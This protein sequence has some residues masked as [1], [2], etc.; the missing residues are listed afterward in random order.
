[1]VRS[2]GVAAGVTRTVTQ[3]GGETQVVLTF[4]GLGT[5]ARSLGDGNWTLKV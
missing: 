3:G 2:D 4:S 1:M 5:T